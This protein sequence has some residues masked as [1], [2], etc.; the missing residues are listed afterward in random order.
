M[1]ITLRTL[2]KHTRNSARADT[3]TVKGPYRH[4]RTGRG[5]RNSI[6]VLRG[7]QSDVYDARVVLEFG[8]LLKHKRKKE[9]RKRN[10]DRDSGP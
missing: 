4:D 2:N 3:H 9:A 6:A 8:V 7:R 10:T 5:L 1:N